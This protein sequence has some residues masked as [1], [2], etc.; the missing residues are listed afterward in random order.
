MGKYPQAWQLGQVQH[1]VLCHAAA[2]QVDL[3]DGAAARDS[4]GQQ[5]GDVKAVEVAKAQDRRGGAGAEEGLRVHTPWLHLGVL[6]H[7]A[8]RKEPSAEV[9][10]TE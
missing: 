1:A 4:R 8:K 7:L 10:H 6:A 9:R 3:L 5:L 2:V